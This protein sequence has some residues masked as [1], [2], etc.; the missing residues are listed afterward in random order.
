MAEFQVT[1]INTHHK[2]RKGADHA[3]GKYRYN[4]NIRILKDVINFI[5]KIDTKSWWLC[6][7]WDSSFK[8]FKK[9]WQNATSPIFRIF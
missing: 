8:I 9:F 7:G 1:H 3:Q 5:L 6:F 4:Q 2:K